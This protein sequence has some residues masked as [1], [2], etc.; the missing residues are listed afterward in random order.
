[1]G[2][3][4]R[5]AAAGVLALAV[6]AGLAGPAVAAT[7]LEEA[8]DALS[9]ERGWVSSEVP[10]EI[11]L[12]WVLSRDPEER[13]A[14]AVL[15]NT[16]S[17]E[18]GS[19]TAAASELRAETAWETVVVALGDDLSASSAHIDGRELLAIANIAEGSGNSLESQLAEAVGGLAE[20]LDAAGQGGAAGER[21]ASSDESEGSVLGDI[22]GFIF[23]V[24]LV[25]MVLPVG[26]LV[27]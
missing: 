4:R 7:Y 18:L 1:M 9:G 21:T 20:A 8:V 23:S 5:L 15:P 19:A 13:V 14:V 25:G 26:L 10:G 24:V 12:N 11:D 2:Q 17:L 6:A 3:I 27:G 16:A 22:L